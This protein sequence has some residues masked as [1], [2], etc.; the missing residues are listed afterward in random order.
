[1]GETEEEKKKRKDD[2]VKRRGHAKGGLT[3]QLQSL[4]RHTAEAFIPGARATIDKARAAFVKFEEL[5]DQLAADA[6]QPSHDEMFEG[7]HRS[8][9]TIVAA[10]SAMIQQSE[11]MTQQA[12]KC[13]SPAERK[14]A[15]SVDVLAALSLPK[16]ELQMFSGDPR[17]FPRWTHAFDDL[18]A[19]AP[20]TD[21]SKLAR[22]L[23]YTCGRAH[24][25]IK[26]CSLAKDGYERAREILNQ[27]FGDPYLIT[28]AL[29]S[30]LRDGAPVKIPE[31]I[32]M[33]ADE[34]RNCVH[35]LTT[36][37]TLNE[38]GGQS[39]I[40]RIA[41]RLPTFLTDRW[42][43]SAVEYKNQHKVYP[44]FQA[45]SKFLSAEADLLMDPVYGSAASTYN[46][47]GPRVTSANTRVE[48]GGVESSV[49]NQ[50]TR[51]CIRCSG[52]HKLLF[53]DA[54]KRMAPRERL[55]FVLKNN[56]CEVCLMHNHRTPDCKSM[57]VCTV[58][59]CGRKHSKFIHIDD[60]GHENDEP[61][62]VNSHVVRSDK[63]ISIPTV[64]VLVEGHVV[65]A[66][67]DTASDATFCTYELARKFAFSRKTGPVQLRT[68][69]STVARHAEFV[70][71]IIRS[72]D[73]S[74]ELALSNVI[75][76][77]R[78]P[79]KTARISLNEF[80]HLYDLPIVFPEDDCAQLL[81]GQ[82][83][84]EALV[85]LEVRTGSANQPFAVRTM[86]G[87]A[88]HGSAP[89][90]HDV[91]FPKVSIVSHFVCSDSLEKRV[92]QF[93]N[94]E[95]EGICHEQSGLSFEDKRV[96]KLWDEGTSFSS[97][98]FE[99]PIPWRPGVSMSNNRHIALSRLRNLDSSLKRRNI[100]DHY[101]AE[102]GKL[103]DEG[104]AELVPVACST[105]MPSRVWYLPHHAVFNPKKPGKLRIVFDC[106]AAH[107]GQSLNDACFSGPDLN[108]RLIHVLL[109][110]RSHPF[111][112]TADVQAMY[113]QV[114]IPEKDRDA[115]RFLWFDGSTKHVREFRMTRH[116]FGGVWCAASATYALRK[117]L[118]QV[119][120]ASSAVKDTI[121]RSFYVDDCLRSSESADALRD[122]AME[123]VHVLTNSGFKL[124][125]FVSNSPSLLSSL[126]DDLKSSGPKDIGPID[127]SKV[128]GIKW[129]VSTD[130]FV[131]D[132]APLLEQQCTTRRSMLSCVSSLF[133]PIGLIA[134]VIVR[135]KLLVQ[136]AA[137][138][139]LAWDE[140]IP[141]DLEV[142]WRAWYGELMHMQTLHVPR[143]IKPISEC[144]L[145]IHHFSDAS[146]VA[147]GCCSYLRSVDGHGNVN[148]HLLISKS[149][150][151]PL[152]KVSVP[153]LELEAAVLSARVDVMLRAELDLPLETSHFWVDSEVV[154]KYIASDSSR[155]KTYVANRVS[156]I[157]E[158]S[159]PLQ[160]HHIKGS[161]NVADIVSRGRDVSK[162]DERLWLMGPEF[163][164]MPESRWN[165]PP[166]DV[167]LDDDPEL[168][169]KTRHVAAITSGFVHPIERLCEYFSD[170]L[171]LKKA[172]AWL[173]RLKSLLKS[174]CRHVAVSQSLSFH[175]MHDAETVIVKHIQS[176]HF[177]KEAGRIGVN[178]P[179][180]PRSA[181]KCLDPFLA[182][183]GLLRV[184]GRLRRAEQPPNSSSIHPI[185]IPHRHAA[186]T[187]IARHFHQ[188]AH[189]GVE[190][191][192]AEIRK[193]YWITRVRSVVKRVA[194]DCVTCRK[195]FS[196][197]ME[198]KMA[199]LPPSRVAPFQPP[200][201][202]TGI[203][204]FGP[205]LVKR[206]RA[207]CKRYGCIFTC[208]ST[209]AVH[210]ELL[211]SLETQSFCNA[212]RRFVARRGMPKEIF[213][214]N[215]TNFVGAEKQLRQSVEW[216]FRVPHASHQGGVWERLIRTVRK[217]LAGVVPRGARLTDEGLHT[218]LCEV[219]RLVNSRPI[220][221]NSDDVNDGGAL[222]PNHV[223]MFNQV[224]PL[225][226]GEF[227]E[228]D[229]YRC[230]W[231]CVQ[232][233]VDEFW[234]RWLREY[235]P[236][237]QLRVKWHE[238]K[239]NLRVGDVVLVREE[240]TPRAVWPLG[241]ITEVNASTDDGLV[242]SAKVRLRNQCEVWRPVQKLVF[243]ES[244]A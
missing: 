86:F 37:G 111:A 213:S 58:P 53:C 222:T 106:A 28:E 1:M 212:F 73:G 135:G 231:R 85:P 67:L 21:A 20:I 44:T 29:L 39:L 158:V 141:N 224:P 25:A 15:P 63:E 128:L 51:K 171:R 23:Q 184:G 71:F 107:N 104:Y 199:N 207:E 234:R 204:C 190:W 6:E 79:T 198:Q 42:K 26:T 168:K 76:V 166:E 30:P 18:V 140:Q 146:E 196:P 5:H 74:K 87:W 3:K 185:L 43:R 175:E 83:N 156:F 56:L 173:L 216:H 242:R 202:V 217:V 22:L 124:T 119:E 16:L 66:V 7:V 14:D 187:L 120:D 33:L 236:L 241:L 8:Y 77:D 65:H 50:P 159:Q 210:L 32:R 116:L 244:S 49:T 176:Y 161:E 95:N 160:W 60:M 11:K 177:Q 243:L 186:A 84:A 72:C 34:L 129:Q 164:R 81:I 40:V 211:E 75:L 218:I 151:A 194:H 144:S 13:E 142:A 100:W 98:H 215:G 97:G 179:L 121:L 143:C 109:R 195:L 150:V 55:D 201:H 214:D 38:I 130:E 182:D 132:C 123:T 139:K 191:V 209:R 154:L 225:A 82:D 54:F 88:L 93:W 46:P 113:Y 220:T 131:F 91:K 62:V 122:T 162:V 138:L 181:I 12:L 145:Q 233:V 78:I 227:H 90:K 148:A 31:E 117:S 193:H 147:F 35:A 136:E 69:S 223:L 125:K 64:S 221:K 230:R 80:D 205:F 48:A 27:R 36:A 157:R 219:E 70:N 226:P 200:F 17:D 115:L 239:R 89:A 174:R 96:L 155:F 229:I 188:M 68:L 2:L 133:D 127:Q 126:P 102:M 165:L 59:A 152:K 92:E 180:A 61:S 169:M 153:R 105:S 103:M 19:N 170:W 41:Q 167:T 52:K 192:I 57:Y 137:K 47:K 4:E 232:H 99:M 172:V 203:D 235:L 189:L 149:R 108:N 228:A 101:D 178:M 45:F 112:F 238:V 206:G 134:P 110:F 118:E 240:V 208:F 163:L 24:D 9:V 94:L 197:P 237:L 183:D 114:L 10:A